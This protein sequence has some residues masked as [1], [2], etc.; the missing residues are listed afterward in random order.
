M[1][2]LKRGIWVRDTGGNLVNLEYACDIFRV[3]EEN[4]NFSIVVKFVNNNK[5]SVIFE[6]PQKT[7][8]E[9]MTAL[10][11]RLGA[12]ELDGLLDTPLANLKLDPNRPLS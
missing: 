6:G 10:S 5:S 8:N 7:A 12:E 9:V 2:S 11:R 4:G 3:K 1:N